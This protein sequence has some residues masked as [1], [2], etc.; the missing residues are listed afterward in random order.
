M[1]PE[2]TPHTGQLIPDFLGVI[3]TRTCNLACLYCGFG[4]HEAADDYLDVE[5]A[6][7]AVN[8]MAEMARRQRRST[9]DVHFFGGE[10]LCAMPV[11]EAVVHRTRVVAAETGLVPHLELA[12]NGCFD[13]TIARFVADYFSTVVLSLDGPPAIQDRHRPMRGGQAS[14]TRVQETALRLGQTS[15]DLCLRMCVTQQTVDDLV[16]TT[17]FLCTTFHP[18]ALDFEPLQDTPE[19]AVA[20]L[21][22]PDPFAFAGAFLAAARVAREYGVQAVYAAAETER[23][24]HTFCPVGRDTVILGPDGRLSACYLRPRDWERCGLDL[25][26][27]RYTPE[28]GLHVDVDAIA[29]IRDLTATQSRCAR[30]IARWY[31]A[32]G[33]HVNHS[34]PGCGQNYD[35]FCIQTRLI[36]VAR[37]LEGVDGHGELE[38][39]LSD[40]SALELVATRPSDALLDWNGE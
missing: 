21:R 6:I 22:P 30:C 24:R 39:L 31:C 9:L 18:T 10:P 33:C 15:V 17:R 32:G 23:P 8:W 40:R 20:G 4:A 25:Y 19:S 3:P 34:H 16:E 35:D 29:R 12:T 27:G 2:P 14:S 38:R 28:E 11:V 5:T 26:Y 7:G 13:D 1:L 37:L 36:V